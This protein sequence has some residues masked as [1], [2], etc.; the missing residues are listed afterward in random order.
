MTLWTLDQLARRYPGNRPSSLIGLPERLALQG[1]SD[2]EVRMICLDFDLG[3]LWF[4]RW[5]DARERATKEVPVPKKERR[6]QTRQVPKY[7]TLDEVLGITK[8]GSGTGAAP[9]RPADTGVNPV[10]EQKVDQL[11]R[12]PAALVAYL[13]EIGKG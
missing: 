11:R 4:G 6:K 9:A 2:G 7:R 13:R 8:P 10:V 1:F 5:T 12:D 3:C